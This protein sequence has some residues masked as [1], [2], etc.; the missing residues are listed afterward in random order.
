MADRSITVRIGANVTGLVAGLKTATQASKD[1]GSK[2]SGFIT[3]NE[4]HINTLSNSL[5]VLGLAATAAAGVAVSRFSDFDSA[6]SGV[7]AATLES[8]DNMELLRRA[9]IE[10]G[11]DTEFSATEAAD[12]VTALAKAGVSTA[13]VL[14]GALDGAL[15]LAAAGQMDVAQAAEIAATTMTQF[16]KSGRDVSHIADLLAAGAGKAQGEV[17]DMAAALKYAGVPLAQLGVSMEETAG[18]IALF[19]KNG[20]VGE[21]AGTS[22]RSMIASLTSPSALAATTMSEL[23]IAVFDAQGEF[24][25]LDGVAGQLASRMGKLTDQERA[26]ALGRIFGNE[27]LQAANVLY[28][29]GAEGVREWTAAVDDQGFAAEQARIKTDNLRGD[30]ER[31]GGSLDTVLIQSGSG[32]NGVLREMAQGAEAVV[33]QIGKLPEPVLTATTLIAGSAGLAL[34]GTAGMGKLVIGVNDTVQAFKGLNISAKTAGIAVGAVGGTIAIAT[35]GLAAWA[36]QQAEAAAYVAE[37]AGTL[38]DATG[39]ITRNTREVVSNKLAGQG[40]WWIFKTE[41]AFDAA[42][43]LG[44]SLDVVTDAAMGNVEALELVQAAVRGVPLEEA[45]RRAEAAGVSIGDYAAA[46]M[47]LEDSVR[48]SSASLEEAIDLARQNDEANADA[49]ESA[50]ELGDAMQY[51]GVSTEEATE[52]LDEWRQMV[53]DADAAFIGVQDAYT[54]VITKNQEMAQATADATESAEDDW[55]EYYDGVSVSAG[56]FIAQLQAQVDAQ[57]AWEENM[58]TITQ[59]VKDGMTGDMA[60]A[61]NAMIDELLELGPEGAAQVQLLKDM[62]DEQF[63]QVVTL[64]RN[65]GATAVQEF[66][67]QVESYR[68]PVI[69]LQAD[70]SSAQSTVNRFINDN[71]GRTIMLNAQGQTVGF[72]M[73]AGA[74]TGWSEGGYTGA[75]GKYDPAGVVHRG[76]FVLSQQRTAKYWSLLNAIHQDRVPGYA[77][78]GFVGSTFTA[79]GPSTALSF[80]AGD[81]AAA[82]DGVSMTLVTDAGPI[83]AIARVE[84]V[85][86]LRTGA[87]R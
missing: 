49:K 42:E 36:T 64:W 54:S 72:K 7:R 69:T 29:Q 71:S 23:G 68:Q 25:G 31:L 35:I 78:G 20:I 61:A 51:V 14:G 6:M 10:A 75:G 86:T 60:E 39:S 33:D 26:N 11:A 45:A 76:E 48:G 79:P 46:Q 28:D 24:I 15:D 18:T 57:T 50:T 32:A 85:R 17:V 38:D 37:L 73:G 4:Q 59:R 44:L 27:S 47:T 65:K 53:S 13:D 77:D 16:G 21:Q 67:T 74:Q 12:A 22:L 84:A 82:F 43:K 2:T 19:A 40:G 58:L 80:H 34:L 9:A 30:I 81:L 83:R 8:A 1:F 63:A 87:R 5:G 52:A 66:T 41:S 70:V 56:D 62:S 3:R 55:Q